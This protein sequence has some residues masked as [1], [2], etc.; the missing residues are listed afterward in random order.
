VV[1]APAPGGAAV[2]VALVAEEA[3]GV[4]ALRLLAER[5]EDVVAV[6]TTP[7]PEKGT[8]VATVAAELAVPRLEPES[9]RDPAFAG[10]IAEQGIDLLLNVHS[11]VIADGA[12]LAAPRI[13][14]FNLHPAPLPAYAGLNSPSWAIA[15]G[16]SRH[17][18][19]LHWMTA[20]VDAG[21]IAY[22]SWF[23]IAPSDTGL[24]VAARCVREGI[25]LFERLL[26]DA[27]RG[28][29]P[30]LPQSSDGGSWHGREVPHDGRLPWQLGARR[31]ADLVR[32]ADYAP[33]PSPWGTF[34]TRVGG[35][36]LDIVR[37]ARTGE[38]SDAPAGTIGPAR[39][40]GVP[41]SAGD[42]WVLVERVRSSGGG[43]VD[44]AEALPT[45]Q[46]CELPR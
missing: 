26:D 29:I 2:R 20:E 8:T 38:P 24:R 35:D 28:T 7:P 17:A 12:V 18:V 43:P 16:E 25:P 19:T 1:D 14:S 6:L 11:L 23:E 15:E 22:E 4:H 10:W 9:M 30:A 34:A 21:A 39:D 41:V 13:G 32:A 31:V 42:E 45:G 33:F 37:A 46:R 5:G 27:A 3:A 36:E 40:G 44:P